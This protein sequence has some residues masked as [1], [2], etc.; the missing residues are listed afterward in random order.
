MLAA[1]SSLIM[2]MQPGPIELSWIGFSNPHPA[3]HHQPVG[4]R[5]EWIFYY[6]VLNS[7]PLFSKV[8]INA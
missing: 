3:G 4:I 1:H 7:Q 8:Q 5:I 2:A 6:K